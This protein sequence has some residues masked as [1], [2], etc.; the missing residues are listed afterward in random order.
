MMTGGKS[1]S[2]SWTRTNN[3]AVSSQSLYYFAIADNN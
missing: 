2:P 1:G 3:L